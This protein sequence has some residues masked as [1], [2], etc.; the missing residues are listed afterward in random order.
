MTTSAFSGKLRV[1]RCAVRR[2]EGSQCQ[3]ESVD[4]D[5]GRGD[6]EGSEGRLGFSRDM[7]GDFN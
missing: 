2:G 3:K 1:E 6:G 7:V 4:V 5:V